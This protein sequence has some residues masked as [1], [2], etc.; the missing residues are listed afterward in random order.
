MVRMFAWRGLALAVSLLSLATA[1][2]ASAQEGNGTGHIAGRIL[3]AQTGA[4]IISAQVMVEGTQIGVLSTIG[5]RYLIRNLAPGTYSIRVQHLAHAPKTITGIVVTAG[6]ATELDVSLETQAVALDAI[7]VTA[8]AERGNTVALLNQRM[9]AP[10]SLDAIG[11]EEISRTPDGDAA[12]A[13]KRVPGLSVVDGKFAYIRGLG[14]RYS[15]TSLNGAPLASPVPDKN[16]VPLDMF[17]TNLLESV[18]T[19]KTYTP[20]QPGDYAGGHVELRTRDYPLQRELRFS[21]STGYN[22]V[23][24]FK[25]GLGY[26]GGGLDFLGFD[27]GTRDLPATIPADRQVRFG[28][29]FSRAELE[30]IGKSFGGDWGPTRQDLRPP[31]SASVSLGDAVQIFGRRLGY[32]GSLNWS[33]SPSMRGDYIERQFVG[34]NETGVIAEI[35]YVGRHTVRNASLGGLINMAYELAPGHELRS[36]FVYSSL[37]EDEAREYEGWNL[38]SNTDQLN[39]RIRFLGQSMSNGQVEGT[40]LLGWLGQSLLDWRAGYTRAARYEPGTREVLYRQNPDGVFRWENFIQSGSVFHQELEDTGGSGAVSLQTPFTLRGLPSSL[41]LGAS[42]QLR[43]RDVYTR[44]FRFSPAPGGFIDEEIRAL[45][46]NELLDPG[47]IARDGFEINEATFRSDNYTAADDR[48]AA[49]A[50]VDLSLHRRLRAVAGARIERTEQIVT[51]HDLGPQNQAPLEGA[52]RS[53]TEVLPA[54]NVTFAWTPSVNLRAGAARTL[55]RPELRELAP[56]NF[57]D[58]AGGANVI[59]NPNLEITTIDNFDLR[60]EWFFR[61]SAVVSLSGF[62]KQFRNPIE[63]AILPST[64]LLKTWVNVESADNFGIEVEFRSDL[65]LLSD[66]LENVSLNTNVTFVQSEVQTG[67]TVP[68]YLPGTGSTEVTLSEED[69]PLQGQSDYVINAG[70]TWIT[71]WGASASGLFN[72]FGQ[73]IDAVGGISLPAEYEEARSQLDLVFEQ[74]LPQG[75]SFKISA[76]RLMGNVVTFKQFDEVLREYDLGR[77]IS[78]SLSWEM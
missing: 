61:P 53:S 72:R 13:L 41:K 1:Q 36:N 23:T 2:P 31:L 74:P 52:D 76:N 29:G 65:G 69:R 35:D 51:P 20:D 19:S 46:P 75:A 34:E 49:F 47:H 71:P 5:G 9:I 73:R 60:W 28:A 37:S 55:A 77:S 39:T 33:D 14:E 26:A 6:A 38:D 4:E 22:T 50:M 16:V 30:T 58:Y 12:E 67:G 56:F 25:D 3:N 7:E 42:A 78:V 32:I 45:Q 21:V 10:A 59:G 64:E 17:P 48:T 44:R 8:T 40:H 68:V 57:A 15:S 24:T 70:L 11:R 43:D 62:Y 18:V 66:E 27:D 63:V 54:V